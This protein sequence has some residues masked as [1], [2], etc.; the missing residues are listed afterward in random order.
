MPKA[1]FYLLKDSDEAARRRFACRL[2]EQQTRQGQRVFLLTSS[3]EAAHELD[4]LLW[5]YTP[6]S[7][8]PHALSGDDHSQVAVVV[9]HENRRDFGC[10]LNLGDT[11]VSDY[12]GLTAVAEFILNDETAKAASRSRWNSYKQLGYELQLHQL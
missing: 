12:P 7:F 9:G 10:V 5:S 11:I 1:N 8:L 2:A 4:Q 6:E 3:A